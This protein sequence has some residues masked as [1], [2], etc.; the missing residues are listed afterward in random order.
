MDQK[1]LI[2]AQKR[3]QKKAS[4]SEEAKKE[5][6]DRDAARKRE[7]RR[8]I[9]A[10]AV[11][12][13]VV[14]AQIVPAVVAEQVVEPASL[15]EIQEAKRS[16]LAKDA[17]RKRESRRR[18]LEQ[19]NERF[20]NDAQTMALGGAAE[21]P[22]EIR[23]RVIAAQKKAQR[24]SA[25]EEV[26]A[27]RRRSLQQTNER[28]ANDEQ[29]MAL[30]G[31]AEAHHETRNRV[32][33]AQEKAQRAST[34]EQVKA[35]KRRS[36]EQTNERFAN[37]TQQMAQG[38]AAEAP[39]VTKRGKTRQIGAQAVEP[40]VETAQVIPAVVPEHVVVPASLDGYQKA[41][42]LRLE[43]EATRKRVSRRRSLEQAN[44]RLATDAEPMARS[45]E[46]TNERI[47]N[48]TQ[49]MAQGGAAEAPHETRNQILAA[50]KRAQRATE[51]VEDQTRRR[52]RDA[53]RQREYII[54]E[55]LA[56]E[57]VRIDAIR[58][59]AD[60]QRKA[61]ERTA[62]AFDETLTRR[63]ADAERHSVAYDQVPMVE[64][65][66]R[67]AVRTAARRNQTE[68]CAL[69]DAVD[70]CDVLTFTCGPMN[71]VCSA[72]GALHFK[73]ERNSKRL[74]SMCCSKGQVK[75]A[76]LVEYPEYF[77]ELLSD[78]TPQAKHYYKNIRDYNAHLGFA[79][80]GSTLNRQPNRHPDRPHNARTVGT[81]SG[82][83]PPVFRFQGQLYHDTSAAHAQEDHRPKYAQLYFIDSEEATRHRCETF[84]AG[85]AHIDGSIFIETFG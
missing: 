10:Q 22:H 64:R 47:A 39:H 82:R 51:S 29:T 18:S 41:K 40:V 81:V 65:E 66:R 13:V 53:A 67:V 52:A 16:R 63:T 24:A 59:E 50:K 77:R 31:A 3:A 7:K 36:L 37:N 42:R 80:C 9:G 61:D 57:T 56:R 83:G 21:A 34:N 17:L 60:A 6:R 25:N 73:K 44:E 26:T 35:Q 8:Q 38:G 5:M 27:Q 49:Q 20:A 4:L 2:A 58:L 78:G 75:L 72:C 33:A 43:K 84:V 28:F 68:F 48:N 32:I 71:V 70:R 23:D 55:Q 15:D 45:L 19:T 62:E 30:G 1:K 79:S 69:G 74:F 76:P 11:E 12:P 14:T 46:Q 54:N 85:R